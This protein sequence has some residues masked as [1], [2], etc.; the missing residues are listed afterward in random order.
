[1]AVD[2]ITQ[3]AKVLAGAFLARATYGAEYIDPAFHV[4]GDNDAEKADDYRGY[5]ESQG[6]W[7]LLD[8]SDLPTFNGKGG[9]ARFTA[10]GLY[11]ARV[12]AGLTNSFDAQGL[13]A[14]KDGNTLVLAFRG[15]D[16]MD[17]A[18]EDGQAFTGYS[19]AANYKAFRPLI[20][21]A[22]DYVAAHPE[23]TDVVVSGHSLGGALA[24]V[25]ALRDAARFRDLRP[26]GLTIVSLGSSGVPQDLPVHLGGL[27]PAAAVIGRKSIEI[28]PFVTIK[29]PYIKQLIR[30]D[31][32]IAIANTEDRARFADNYPDIPEAPGLVPV[33]TLKLNLHFGGDLLFDLPNIENTDVQYDDVLERPASFRGM[34][35]EHNSALLWTNL[36]ALASDG[37]F[38]HYKGQ[39]LIMGVADYTQVPD[40]NGNPIR[41][42]EGYIDL[43]NPADANDWNARRL[44]GTTGD[45]YI[46]GLS[47]H[48]HIEGGSGRDLL[49]GGAGD[50]VI[51]GDGGADRLWG[52]EGIDRLFGGRG[53]DQF[54]FRDIS[55]SL[56]GA[57]DVIM[58]FSRAEGDRMMLRAIDASVSQA[59]DQDFQFIGRAA[60]TAEGQVRAIQSGD[61]T[62]LRINTDGT[63]GAD[64]EIL[65]RNVMAADLTADDFIL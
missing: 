44:L 12:E 20:N 60:F 4:G 55:E 5:V 32:Y 10:N 3:S 29:V 18:V 42:F 49:S 7:R 46:L 59:G 28:L 54:N 2:L 62:I 53:A 6:N 48:D 52:G 14:V 51:R 35:A 1:M 19:I 16:G 26:D 17:P 33:T 39:T 9:D 40:F 23:I 30:P 22:Y 15:T 37:L 58:D 56:P 11:D 8:A 41:L 13:L 31:D 45:D 61:H 50:D 47:G 64:M 57:R 65:L 43:D 36:Q 63:R 21:A 27:D 38:Q 34:G 25:F 24:D